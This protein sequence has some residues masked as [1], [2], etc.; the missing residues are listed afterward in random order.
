MFLKVFMY[1]LHSTN[2]IKILQIT[3]NKDFYKNKQVIIWCDS[4]AQ[5][6]KIA[7]KNQNKLWKTWKQQVRGEGCSKKQ[8]YG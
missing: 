7:R 6:W 5:A 4:G 3:N 8:K 2:L 1:Y